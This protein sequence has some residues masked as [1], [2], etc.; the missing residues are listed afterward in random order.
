[1]CRVGFGL[2]DRSSSPACRGDWLPASAPGSAA[3]ANGDTQKRPRLAVQGRADRPTITNGARGSAERQ[4]RRQVK[5]T[6]AKPI[7]IEPAGAAA[8]ERAR[9]RALQPHRRCV[10]G[11]VHLDGRYIAVTLT[12]HWRERCTWMDGTDGRANGWS[13]RVDGWS[14]QRRDGAG[15]KGRGVHLCVTLRVPLGYPRLPLRR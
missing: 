12:L 7:G 8:D 4:G 1:M 15:S 10:A 3:H 13:G 11:E 6:G 5:S 14:E 2:C 9:E